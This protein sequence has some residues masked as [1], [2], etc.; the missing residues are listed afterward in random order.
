MEKIASESKEEEEALA[1]VQFDTQAPTIAA[2]RVSL[3]PRTV[4]TTESSDANLEEA[5]DDEEAQEE[6]EEESQEVDSDPEDE[7]EPEEE[8]ENPDDD[9]AFERNREALRGYAKIFCGKILCA[10]LVVR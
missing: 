6:S 10:V 1:D 4:T 3:S 9:G 8:P 7:E 5:S 2:N